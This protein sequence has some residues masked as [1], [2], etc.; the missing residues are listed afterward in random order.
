MNLTILVSYDYNFVKLRFSTQLLCSIRMQCDDNMSALCIP[1]Q[2]EKLLPNIDGVRIIGGKRTHPRGYF[3][4][5][6]LRKGG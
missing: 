2:K 3:W 1:H 5:Y 4:R 6:D